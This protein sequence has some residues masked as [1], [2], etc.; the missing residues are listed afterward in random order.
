MAHIINELYRR[1]CDENIVG[2]FIYANVAIYLVFVVLGVLATLMNVVSPIVEI[3]SWLQLPAAPEKLLFQPWSIFT[4]MFLHGSFAHI[5]WNMFALYVFGRIFLTFYSTQHFIGVYLLGGVVGGLFFVLAYNIFPYFEG[6]TDSSYLVGASAAVLAIITAAAVRS[7]NYMVNL[8]LF[9][10]V[11]LMTLAIITVVVSF[12]LLSS[13]NAGGNFAHLGGAFAG[14]FF[15]VML[16]QGRDLTSFSRVIINAYNWSRDKIKSLFK[17]HAKGPR[18]DKTQKS[19]K[20]SSDYEYN[21]RKKERND[22]IDIIL[23]KI[24]KSGY[25]SLT[26]DEKRTLFDA[27]G[28]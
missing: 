25:S 7:P 3:V 4:Y 2:K 16:D 8:F 17:K 5:L 27:S 28:K 9:G 15:A 19:A 6:V 11:K 18:A 24:K 12:L 26:E 20:H 23:E 21:A 22:N 14:W 1:F 13:E 10:P